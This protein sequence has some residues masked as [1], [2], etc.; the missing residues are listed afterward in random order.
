MTTREIIPVVLFVYA[1]PDT[2]QRT[3]AALKS[4]PIPLLYVYCDGAADAGVADKVRQVRAM[5]HEIDWCRTEIFENARNLGLGTSIRTGVTDVLSRHEAA[6]VFEDD[7]VCVPGTY[8]YLA[9]ALRHYASVPEVMS[10]SAWTH[11]DVQPADVVGVPHFSGRFACWGWGTWRRAWDGMHVPA[12]KLLRA[13]RFRLRDIYRYGADIPGAAF[14]ERVRNVWAVRFVLLHMLRR[15]LC[16]YPPHS[17][18]MHIGFDQGSTNFR[19]VRVL[20]HQEL[21]VAPAIPKQWPVACEHPDSPGR[22]QGVWGQPP[23]V[24]ARLIEAVQNIRKR[25]AFRVARAQTRHS[26]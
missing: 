11:P 25:I 16:L 5:V 8:E 18:S 19:N 23:G 10:V 1:R 22:W 26:P 6:I 14:Q 21:Q 7:I 17:L 20:E 13:C 12:M 24:K 9:A 4:N 15:G 3:L 2:L